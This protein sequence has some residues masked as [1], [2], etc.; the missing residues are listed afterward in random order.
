MSDLSFVSPDDLHH[1][2]RALRRQRRLKI[3]QG[4]WQSLAVSG[5]AIGV[6]WG[7]SQPIWLVRDSS[8]IQI[9]GNR[10][11]SDQAIQ[12]LIPIDYP[13]SLLKLQPAAIATHLTAASPIAQ[14]TVTR[15]LVPPHLEI[16]VEERIPVAAVVPGDSPTSLKPGFLDAQGVWMKPSSLI[17]LGNPIPSPQLT[18]RGLRSADREH[19][20]SMYQVLRRSPLDVSEIDW[21]NP[22]NLVLKTEVGIAHL[23]AYGA[24]FPEQLAALDQ[25]R[26]LK[27]QVDDQTVDYID[28]S[29]PN[30]PSVKLV[31]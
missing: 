31:P 19:W 4:L 14:A 18:I 16:Q 6:L 30:H 28:V 11:L 5:L 27:S 13:Q 1:R 17:A 23:G 26:H 29:D 24:R 9:E 21:Q 15:R 20:P 12:A 7:A 3:L 25:L 22:D 8:Q 2:R 10:L